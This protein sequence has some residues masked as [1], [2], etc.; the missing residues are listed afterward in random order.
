MMQQFFMI[1]TLRYNL[2]AVEDGKP[3]DLKEYKKE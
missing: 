3:D 1:P 2:L